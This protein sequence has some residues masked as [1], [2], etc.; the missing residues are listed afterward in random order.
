MPAAV[1][2]EEQ[3]ELG[4]ERTRPARAARAPEGGHDALVTTVAAATAVEVAER[5]SLRPLERLT[6]EH[7]GRYQ[8]A[9]ELGE[10]GIGR[11]FVARDAH[12]GRE[13]ALKELLDDVAASTSGRDPGATGA[14][15]PAELRFVKEARITG[16]LE[17]P[18][19][20]PVYELGRR[21]DGS[22]YYTMR[23]VKGR[24]LESA[25]A[26]A[27]LRGRLALL[28]HF[29]DLCNTLAYAHSRGVI[30][31]DLKP[32]N[33]MLGDFGETV[34]LD[35]GL[36]KVRGERDIQ[37]SA[38][39][40]ELD[41]LREASV[42]KTVAGV[43]IGTPGY[44]SPE[45]ALGELSRVDERTDVYSLGVILYQLLS[46]TLPFDGKNAARV[47]ERV[48]YDEPV[49]PLQIEPDCP[50]ELAA[51]AK[52]AMEKKQDQ[53]YADARALAADVRA[54]LTGGLVGA[55]RYTLAESARRFLS[56]HRRRL[57]FVGVVAIVA[58]VA[59]WYRGVDEERRQASLDAEQRDLAAQSVERVFAD[60]AAG[61]LQERWLD[62]LTFKLM[63]LRTPVTEEAVV[64][65]LILALEHPSADVRRLAAR[66]LSA[67][68]SPA[69]VDALIGRLGEDVEPS[70]EVVIEVINAL[71]IIG[72]ARAEEAVRAARV[73]AGQYGHI[74]NQTELAYRMIPLPELEAE[75]TLASREWN[76]L[77]NALL[78]KGRQN[79]ALAAFTRAIEL[80]PDD[81][82]PHNNRAIV[83]RQL[84][85]FDEALGDY[86]RVLE[87]N[88]GDVLALNNRSLLHRQ[89]EH[90]EE[91]LAD[92]DKV[93]AS[94]SLGV[95]ALRN[96]SI[97]R[98]FM[99]DFAGA[100]ADLQLAL[101]EQPDDERTYSAVAGTWV[102]TGDWAQALKALDQAI[103]LN[104]KYTYA[105]SQRA[106]VHYVLGR[107]NDALLDIDRV[108]S[109]DPADNYG[110]RMRAHILMQ[111]SKPA[112]A[113]RDLDYCLENQCINDQSRR[114]LRLAQ[115]AVV[116]Y[117]AIGEHR[118]ALAELDKATS[119]QPHTVDTFTYELAALAVALRMG[120][121]T[122]VGRRERLV[123][124]HHQLGRRWHNRAARILDGEESYDDIL[125]RTLRPLERCV[126]ALAGGIA[127]E[128][129]GNVPDAVA[130]Y[131]DAADAGNPHDLAC[132]LAA[133]A[134]EA[135]EQP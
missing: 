48:I 50:P 34:L 23:Y 29:V 76:E 79:D 91:A 74:W 41:R 99:G 68:K 81:A 135:L 57:A 133:Q 26:G 127:A 38:L 39:K 104:D 14:R 10:G 40:S 12:L 121:A 30:H 28:P 132:V 66:S 114:A 129:S 11:V 111:Q 125:A 94:G 98:R 25:L 84:G 31:R 71:G 54:F 67:V 16:Q 115:R 36:A 122:E 2:R 100:H 46:G 78:W 32:E 17:H 51:I 134:V 105:L 9:G 112:A 87:L 118:V 83:L 65:N 60:V 21:A 89:M 44:M 42:I 70:E 101:V 35:W 130:N 120:D 43:P 110:R 18:G 24:T 128:R 37:S 106:Q 116:Y 19:I 75:T 113:K 102:W 22:I 13:V 5:E 47:I 97:I 85:R 126:V 108:L 7:P 49:D 15:S 72:D 95:K 69:A 131:R 88:P 117:A 55:H 93:V 119:G 61:N 45:Q 52:R 59:W 63:A 124:D 96:R 109:L 4:E 80:T 56:R 103:A 62:V 64:E 107:T 73:H 33:V 8:L 123:L 90:F 86:D 82:M 1:G 20:V 53:R 77:G 6:D 58:A 27:D 92:I 3:G